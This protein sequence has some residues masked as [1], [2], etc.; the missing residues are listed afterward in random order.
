MKTSWSGMSGQIRDYGKR[1]HDKAS[2]YSRRAQQRT[3]QKSYRRTIGI[4]AGMLLVLVVGGV[5]IPYVLP[6]GLQADEALAGR[7]RGLSILSLSG[8]ASQVILEAPPAAEAYTTW[9]LS[10]DRSMFLVAWCHEAKPGDPSSADRMALQLR[11]S[12]SG[13]L[14]WQYALDPKQISMADLQIG[15]IP[16]T[17]DIWLL[18]RGRLWIMDDR[19]GD[20]RAVKVLSDGVLVSQVAFSP[21]GTR[22]AY[23]G[24]ASGGVTM[25][26][27]SD[28][29]G[30]SISNPRALG[31]P[32]AT[33][34]PPAPLNELDWSGH[35]ILSL[36]LVSSNEIAVA[37]GSGTTYSVDMARLD[38]RGGESWVQVSAPDLIYS[39]SAAPDRKSLLIWVKGPTESS[40]LNFVQA[41]TGQS[42]DAPASPGRKIFL[43]DS[44]AFRHPAVWSAP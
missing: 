6:Q 8:R 40:Y 24:A 34:G 28:F 22:V 35:D 16:R 9:A 23:S 3:R 18:S 29:N 43:E 19:N 10:Q 5:A 42:T 41:S 44:Q 32:A 13:H 11:S 37:Q 2:D 4:V 26:A 36:C 21:D 25:V 38:N 27:V 20:V 17:M 33:A 1:A 12:Y 39:M 31:P 14:R 7:G 15:Y 30:S